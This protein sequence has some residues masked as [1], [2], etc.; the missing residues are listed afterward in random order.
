M[1]YLFSKQNCFFYKY[2]KYITN[3]SRQKSISFK[4]SIKRLRTSH[5]IIIF[6]C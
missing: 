3:Y 6:D 5:K 1:V 2:K 4:Y